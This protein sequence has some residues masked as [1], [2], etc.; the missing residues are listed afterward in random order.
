MHEVA[1]VTEVLSRPSDLVLGLSR[2]R[3]G[4]AAELSGTLG[5]TQFVAVG[6]YR[7]TTVVKCCVGIDG[8][9]DMLMAVVLAALA[10]ELPLLIRV[11]GF[12]RNLDDSLVDAVPQ[13]SIRHRLLAHHVAF[14]GRVG[15]HPVPE[16]RS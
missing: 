15:T 10:K 6:E 14:G 2:K 12:T 4:V 11:E 16:L 13:C 5:L 9:R 8:E 7:S 1:P 3:I